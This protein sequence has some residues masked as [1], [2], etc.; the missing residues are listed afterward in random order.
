MLDILF[1]TPADN[2]AVIQETT[3]TMILGTELLAKGFSVDIL[4]LFQIGSFKKDY[5]AFVE[6]M[7]DEILRREPKC[8]SFYPLWIQYHIMLRLAIEIKNRR[9]EIITVFGGPQASFVAEPT[10]NGFAAVDYVCTGEGENTVVPFFRSILQENCAGIEAIPGLC[11]RVDGKAVLNTDP[12]PL[13]DINTIPEW[14]ERLY[15][16][17]YDGEDEQRHP[18][19]YFMP[20]DVGRGCPFNCLF[21]C[22]SNIYHKTYRLKTPE[23]IVNDILHFHNKF[24][25]ESFLFSHDAFTA[26]KKLVEGVCD[27][28]IEQGLDIDW[29][30]ATRVDCLTEELVLKM[31]QAGCRIIQMGIESGSP[32]MQKY[33]RKNLDLDRTREMV[34]FLLKNNFSVTLYFMYGFPEETEEDLNQTLEYLF[35]MI[36]TERIHTNMALCMFF[37]NTDMFTRHMD[38]LVLDPEIKILFLRYFGLEEEL[39]MIRDHKAIFPMYYHLNTPVR[40][41]FQYVRFLSE[42]YEKLTFSA[43]HLRMLYNG[44]N[45]ALYRDFYE[46]NLEHFDGTIEQ[47]SEYFNEHPLEAMC[48]TVRKLNPP[49]AE[50][51][52]ALMEFDHDRRRFSQSREDMTIHKTYRFCYLDLQKKRP[53]SAYSRG[54]TEILLQRKDGVKTTKILDMK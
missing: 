4:R 39:Q 5:R 42:V 46:S 38:E 27:R 22:T 26:N 17:K 21:C 8:V 6:E 33:I 43:R 9:P 24:G 1:I 37:P 44:D 3:G 53:I 47:I 34:G 32:R 45:L 30:A 20:I 41:N 51:L 15:L 36:D 52:M 28:I 40:N 35:S 16:P 49:C 19:D 7:T 25:Y 12:I 48:N 18:R 14:D 31:K 23:R 54:S 29:C 11:R 50:Q 10:L 13:I 2:A